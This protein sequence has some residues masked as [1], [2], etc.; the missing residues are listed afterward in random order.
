MIVANMIWVEYL[1]V[2]DLRMDQKGLQLWGENMATDKFQKYK[3]FLTKT[4]E[5]CFEDDM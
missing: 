5:K 2:I 1:K 3:P 4:E